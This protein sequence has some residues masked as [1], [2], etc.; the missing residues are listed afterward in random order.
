MFSCYN[1]LILVIPL[2]YMLRTELLLFSKIFCFCLV[3]VYWT[4]TKV[5][6]CNRTT[7]SESNGFQQAELTLY[8]WLIL[9]TSRLSRMD[10]LKKKK[11][12]TEGWWAIYEAVVQTNT[13]KA[14]TFGLSVFTGRWK[15]IFTLNLQQNRKNA[16]DNAPEMFANC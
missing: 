6:G 8:K 1:E 10:E 12:K 4:A 5:S 13:T 11:K 9:C 3:I 7:V 16:P 15:I 14:T 2:M